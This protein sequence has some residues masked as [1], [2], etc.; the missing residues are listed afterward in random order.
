MKKRL[1]SALLILAMLVG[2]IAMTVVTSSE[3]D[4]V[5]PFKD[6]KEKNWFYGAVKAVYE[7]QLMEG[8]SEDTFAPLE[9]MTRAQIVTIFYRLA[10]A[11]ETGLGSTLTFTDTKATAWYADYLGWAVKE[12]LVSGYPEGTFRPNAPVSRQELAKLIVV[13]LGYMGV[14]I[15]GEA[16]VDSFADADE[17]PSWSADYIEALRMTGLVGGDNNGKFNPKN[18]ANRAEIATIF[19]RFPE[20]NSGL[21][22]EKFIE[23]PTE[24][25]ETD[26]EGRPVFTFGA[27]NAVGADIA[28][29]I[30]AAKIIAAS[31]LDASKYTVEFDNAAALFAAFP[32]SE[33]VNCAHGS[34]A[35]YSEIPVKFAIKDI[36]TGELTDFVEFPE[37]TLNKDMA[38]DVNNAL[39]DDGYTFAFNDIFGDEAS[40][41]H[42]IKTKV[43]T[44]HD[45]IV[46]DDF[47]AIEAAYAEK[48]TV[49]FK[50]VF[51]VTGA[52]PAITTERT[53]TVD[54]ARAGNTSAT[55]P[56][57]SNVGTVYED[58]ATGL[59]ISQAMM[60]DDALGSGGNI[61]A[62]GAGNH[63]WHESRIVRT[64]NGT[65]VTFLCEEKMH[66]VI[67]SYG[68]YDEES[69]TYQYNDTFEWDELAVVKITSE[70][71]KTVL[72][73]VWFPHALGSCT[74]NINQLKNG[75]ILVTVIAEDKEKYY[76]SWDYDGWG[77]QREGAWLRVYEIDTATDTLVNPDEEVYRPD[78]KVFGTHGYGYSQPII[79]E[80][81][82]MLYCMYNSGEVPGYFTW[83][84]YDLN[85]H[86]WVGGPYFV[87]I[88]SR[89]GYM[90]IYPDGNG[91]VFFIAQRH[92]PRTELEK[93]LGITFKQKNG[94]GFDS[95]YLFAIP[96]MTKE[97]CILV[98]R[99][100]EPDYAK[101][102]EVQT[103]SCVHYGNGTTFLDS[104]GH[105]H[106]LYTVQ[107]RNIDSKTRLYH[108]IY[109]VRDNYRII[110]NE[111]IFLN[112][113]KNSSY[114]VGMAENTSGD[115]FIIAINSYITKT[116][117]TVEVYRSED[118][119]MSFKQLCNAQTITIKG[120]EGATLEVS[121][122]SFSSTR[123]HS[124]QDNIVAI[125]TSNSAP[126]GSEPSSSGLGNGFYAYY[127]YTV[128]LPE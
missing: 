118:G 15:E 69:G 12:N 5:L 99:T 92:P 54:F 119:G 115:L 14:T 49:E 20:M 90:N 1:L 83:F 114:A 13:F 34:S 78:F 29:E 3:D 86:E 71:C 95:A 2:M 19:S 68:E 46:I 81:N 117:V 100:Y 127:Y 35:V 128:E 50:A 65:Y 58:E 47:A 80:E 103:A 24:Y 38:N 87:E 125:C 108:A 64:T 10:G 26:E 113:R 27:V 105:L 73:N 62:T 102:V 96:D 53:Y 67:Y 25:L 44:S 23:N 93:L 94:Y 76:E 39:P 33:Y 79:D 91:G 31:G 51:T 43:K 89:C 60:V 52:E 32:G 9:S 45:D 101:D 57:P 66:D 74:A 116:E 6:V 41:K 7:R 4:V 85:K 112:D 82:G 40:F 124:T 18:N 97:E 84:N 21:T 17:F 8:V 61:F 106:I 110:K 75:N 22:P 37:V 42:W 55:D 123:N 77:F 48:G 107:N 70:G 126:A 28:R 109:D 30:F 11:T 72:R 120:T 122:H 56:A 121:R 88:E 111:Q 59:K 104:M 36:E 63:G 98:D 16:L